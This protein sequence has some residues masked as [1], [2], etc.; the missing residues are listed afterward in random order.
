MRASARDMV[1]SIYAKSIEES[2]T[3]PRR[4]TIATSATVASREAARG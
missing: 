2:T 4:A 3:K 1:E